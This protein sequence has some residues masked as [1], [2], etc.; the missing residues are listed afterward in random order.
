MEQDLL[1]VREF[2]HDGRYDDGLSRNE[3]QG[4]ITMQGLVVHLTPENKFFSFACLAVERCCGHA[5]EQ[6][7]IHAIPQ[8]CCLRAQSL[9]ARNGTILRFRA[10][11]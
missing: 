7:V 5:R 3:V 8:D 10:L 1:D 6:A 9:C 4:A 2:I 11:T